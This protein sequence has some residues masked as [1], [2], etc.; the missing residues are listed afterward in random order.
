MG[1][2]RVHRSNRA[3]ILAARFGNSEINNGFFVEKT[4]AFCHYPAKKEFV[5]VVSL[6]TTS[7]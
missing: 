7:Q 2:I 5:N 4:S 6:Q 3:G 1:R